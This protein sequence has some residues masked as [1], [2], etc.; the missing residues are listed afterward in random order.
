MTS[1]V[2]CCILFIIT[3]I[4]IIVIGGLIIDGCPLGAVV[5]AIF[6]IGSIIVFIDKTPSYYEMQITEYQ[7]VLD[8][9]PSCMKHSPDDIACLH[10]Y[11]AWVAD[12]IDKAYKLDSIAHVRDSIKD[13]INSLREANK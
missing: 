5:A 10:E 11:K 9:P 3:V 7:S 4:S 1:S 2:F 13:Y 8:N 6:G 12:S